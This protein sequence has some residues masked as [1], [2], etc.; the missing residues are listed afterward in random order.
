MKRDYYEVLGVSRAAGDEENKKP[1]RKLALKY[2]PD[3]NPDDRHTAEER[4][5]E[6]VEAYQVL[7][8]GERRSL[9]DRFGPAAVERGGRAGGAVRASAGAR[10]A[11]STSAGASRTS[12]VTC[13]GTSSVAAA[14]AAGRGA[15]RTS[16]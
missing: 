9:S 15:A 4:F 7:C 3:K 13:P 6:L 2:H 1:Y 14:D 5:K 16:V 8:D 10:P 12:S 11:P